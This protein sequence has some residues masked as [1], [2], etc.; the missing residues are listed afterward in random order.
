MISGSGCSAG[1]ARPGC[2]HQKAWKRWLHKRL[3]RSTGMGYR[4]CHT[5]LMG[6]SLSWLTWSPGPKN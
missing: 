4:S 5:I 1:G 6:L 3:K 2:W